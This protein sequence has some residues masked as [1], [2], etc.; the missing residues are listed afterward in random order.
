MQACVG[1]LMDLQKL[2]YTIKLGPASWDP[3]LHGIKRLCIGMTSHAWD[4]SSCE[5]RID[6]NAS[7]P[8]A[9]WHQ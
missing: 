3:E 6:T 7:S 4:D 1:R 2:Q 9:S 8:A 5:S